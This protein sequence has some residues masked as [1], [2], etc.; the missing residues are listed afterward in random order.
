M[1]MLPTGLKVFQLALSALVSFEV[2]PS[3]VG[4]LLMTTPWRAPSTKAISFK[5][6]Q[7]IS[8]DTEL[9]GAAEG[10]HPHGV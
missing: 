7:K 6:S 9:A 1:E 2:L 5:Q 10:Q 8:V 3:S 4:P